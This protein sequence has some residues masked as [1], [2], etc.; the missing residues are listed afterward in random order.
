MCYHPPAFRWGKGLV[1]APSHQKFLQNCTGHKPPTGSHTQP[2]T[3]IHCLAW[4]TLTYVH[5]GR[6]LIFTPSRDLRLSIPRITYVHHVTFL[7]DVLVAPTFRTDCI[8]ARF[9]QRG[10][11]DIYSWITNWTRAEFLEASRARLR[12][13]AVARLLRATW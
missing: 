10:L 6:I 8:S 11:Q 5:H 4:P 1:L 3:D 13:R 9:F 7:Y 2:F 12:I